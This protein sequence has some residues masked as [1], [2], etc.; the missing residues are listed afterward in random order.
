MHSDTQHRFTRAPSIGI[1]A[2]SLD[3]YSDVITDGDELIIFDRQDQDR[4]IQC[5]FWIAAESME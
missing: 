5:D 3:R 1:D 4:W 2:V